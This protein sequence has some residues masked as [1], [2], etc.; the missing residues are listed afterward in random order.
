MQSEIILIGNE[1]LIGKIKDTNGQFIIKQMLRFGHQIARITIIP[2]CVDTIAEAIKECVS[3]SPAF[4]FISGGLGPTYDDMTFEGIAKA[5][6]VDLVLNETALGFLKQRYQKLKESGKIKY[7]DLNQSRRKMAYLPENATALFNP[8]GAAPCALIELKSKKGFTRIVAMPGFPDELQA[9]FEMHVLPMLEKTHSHY[10]HAGI[11]FKGVG[12]STLA[13]DVMALR[14]D[15]PEIWIKTHPRKTNE[16]DINNEIHLTAFLESD[17][18]EQNEKLKSRINALKE[19]CK[20][21]VERFDGAV[22]DE[23]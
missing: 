8:A 18:K 3:R 20:K 11:R 21:I 4:I 19:K 15:Y 23:Y 17:D 7:S 14:D 22:I 13:A 12:E 9:I 6:D 16:P 10:Y 2:D 1:L 5:F